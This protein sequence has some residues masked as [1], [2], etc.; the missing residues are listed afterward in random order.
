MGSD[1]W[2]AN[3]A[4]KYAIG[5]GGAP[6][7]RWCHQVSREVRAWSKEAIVALKR[8]RNDGLASAWAIVSGAI[9]RSIRTGLC[10]VRRQSG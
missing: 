10:A 4:E 9:C 5:S 6:G 8:F 2:N 1:W 7:K 3:S